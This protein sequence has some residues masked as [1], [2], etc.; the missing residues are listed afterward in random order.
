MYYNNSQ[1]YT[2]K[3]SV[4]D[5]HSFN[6]PSDEPKILEIFSLVTVRGLNILLGNNQY[7]MR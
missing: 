6:L 4:T 2:T 5:I 7:L 3:D 1:L